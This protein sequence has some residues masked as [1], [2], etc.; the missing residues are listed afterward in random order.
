MDFS[1]KE[2]SLN[3]NY[4]NQLKF[5]AYNQLVKRFKKIKWDHP[6]VL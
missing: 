4:L 1:L 3:L 5:K 2:I 6:K